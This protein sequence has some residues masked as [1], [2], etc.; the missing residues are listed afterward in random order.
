MAAVEGV[1]LVLFRRRELDFHI[2]Q[3]FFWT[4]STSA[5]QYIHN[6]ASRFQM[7]VTNGVAYIHSGSVVSQWRHA[8]GK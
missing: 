2:D 4:D 8:D 1:K 3:E 6:T 5:L 7:F